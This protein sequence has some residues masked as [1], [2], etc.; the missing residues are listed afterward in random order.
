VKRI[1]VVLAMAAWLGPSAMAHAASDT[2]VYCRRTDALVALAAGQPANYLVVGELCATK[3]ELSNGT[4]LQLLV[5]GAT[6]NHDYWDFGNV[7]GKTTRARSPQAAWPP[8][9]W[10]RS[11]WAAAHT[12]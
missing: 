3:E 2:E 12:H 9:L 1:H 11:A 5:H 6:Y 8:W 10:M 4:T 7:Q